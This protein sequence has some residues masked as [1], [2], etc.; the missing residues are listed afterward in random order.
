MNSIF[1]FA[2]LLSLVSF[3]FNA[4]AADKTLEFTDL[5]GAT[6][7]PLQTK[8][9]RAT[10]LLFV[11][12]TCPV[13]NSYAPEIEKIYQHYKGD[14][15]SFYLVQTD[16]D[17]KTS[18]AKKHAADYG[19][20]LPILIDRKHELVKHVGAKMTPEAVVLLSDGTPIYRGRIDNRQAALGKRRPKATIFDLRDTLD[21]ILAGE[22]LRPRT[23]PAIG[24][25]IPETG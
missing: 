17:L 19:Y 6:H 22:K 24:C 16:P 1:T 4:P 21:A 11:W 14:N 15:V 8:E 10:V 25:Y 9:T 18:R 3:G 13:A 20:T 23:T 2:C 5:N 7:T 12:H